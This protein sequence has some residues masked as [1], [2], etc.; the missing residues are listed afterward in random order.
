M[1]VVN[2]EVGLEDEDD[3]VNI[4]GGDKS[5]QILSHKLHSSR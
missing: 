4:T 2:E 1:Q 5:I 3:K